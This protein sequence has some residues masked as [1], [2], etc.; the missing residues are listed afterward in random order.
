MVLRFAGVQSQQNTYQTDQGC[1][2]TKIITELHFSN[3][4]ATCVCRT[5]RASGSLRRYMTNRLTTLL[6][7]VPKLGISHLGVPKLQFTKE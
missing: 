1:L 2:T 5:D 7:N 3:S 6:V 4:Y